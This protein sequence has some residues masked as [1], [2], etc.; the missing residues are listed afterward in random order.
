MAILAPLLSLSLSF[1]C[2]QAHRP[3]QYAAQLIHLGAL[4][5]AI[6]P[7]CN[8]FGAGT[9]VRRMGNKTANGKAE[10]CAVVGQAQC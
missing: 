3:R 2:P 1:R 9:V 5:K 6:K 4:S 10:E 7:T 8:G